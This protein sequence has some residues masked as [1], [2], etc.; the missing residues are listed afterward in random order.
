MVARLAIDVAGG[1]VPRELWQNRD[2]V[3]TISQ[4]GVAEGM[5]G[6]AAAEWNA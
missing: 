4:A 5:G 2:S 1:R 3:T 6:V